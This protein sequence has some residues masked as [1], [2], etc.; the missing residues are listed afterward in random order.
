MPAIGE[1]CGFYVSLFSPSKHHLLDIH[2]D[3]FPIS[4]WD[5]VGGFG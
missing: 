5:D 3:E 1:T 4:Y 2:V